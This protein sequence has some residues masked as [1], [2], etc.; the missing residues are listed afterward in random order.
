[1]SQMAG[2]PKSIFEWLVP[3]DLDRLDNQARPCR[4]MASDDLGRR[5]VDNRASFS[6][7]MQPCAPVMF[8]YRDAWE[9]AAEKWVDS[10]SFP[11]ELAIVR[12]TRRL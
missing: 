11:L 4:G 7:G 10:R 2:S 9:R 12:F 8:G 5:V 6:F 1:M 3:H